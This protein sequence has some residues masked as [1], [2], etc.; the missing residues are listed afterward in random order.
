MQTASLKDQITVLLTYVQNDEFKSYDY[1][2]WWATELGQHAKQWAYRTEPVGHLLFTLPLL[3]CELWL[4]FLRKPFGIKKRIYPITIAHH[5]L[6][7]LERY[8][9][10]G[11]ADWLQN[12]KDDADLL[13]SLAIPGAKGLCWGFPFT[14]SANV[15]IIPPNQPAATQTSYGFDL[16]EQLWIATGDETY[17]DRLLS[18]ARA[19]D[20]EYIDL[21]H[22]SGLAHTYHGRGY[23][24]VIA[25]AI[26]Y[27]MRILAGAAF[28]GAQQ[29]A[30]KARKLALY[31]LKSQRPDGSWLY[32]ETPKNQFIDHYHTCFVIK[33]LHRANLVLSLPEISS[34]VEK[35]IGYYW[36]NLFDEN[37]QPQPFA[38]QIRSN[39]IKYESY[40]FAECLG[41]FALLGPGH[42]FTRE[43]LE[44][45]LQF[46]LRNFVLPDN[47]LRF[48][49]Y[50]FPSAN[51]YP[52]FRFGMTA[53][54]L[55][56]A[57]LLNS[58]FM[59]EK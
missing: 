43:R 16:F 36:E 29:F 12:A 24:D 58:S 8:K 51:G 4:P 23:G 42:G 34:A 48:R 6:A 41:L 7:C 59:H 14:W 39:I 37:G 27:R 17:R 2:D 56:L 20:E 3:A 31:L 45:I 35:G 22:P 11:E 32:G 10:I 52:Y 15:G 28:Y 18:V 44:L 1:Y 21:P 53:A 49:V 9:Y 25:N 50:R 19:M 47:A 55:S 38:K 13:T 30:E 46:F 57:Q 33:N 40:D 26:S 54:I 5:G